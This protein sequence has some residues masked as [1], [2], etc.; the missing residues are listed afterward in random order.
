MFATNFSFICQLRSLSFPVFGFY[1]SVR[2]FSGVF[3]SFS[4][5]FC[6]VYP[7]FPPT[8]PYFLSATVVFFSPPAYANYFELAKCFQT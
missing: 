5:G 3:K 8:I 4:A 7:L 6:L 2:N 1:F